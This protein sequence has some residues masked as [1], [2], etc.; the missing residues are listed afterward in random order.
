MSGVKEMSSFVLRCH[1]EVVHCAA[2]LPLLTHWSV[3]WANSHHP[4]EVD[5]SL[6]SAAMREPSPPLDGQHIASEPYQPP[7]PT[8]TPFNTPQT[9]ISKNNPDFSALSS[10]FHLSF[11]PH[12]LF[13]QFRPPIHLLAFYPFCFGALAKSWITTISFVMSVRPSA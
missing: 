8:S 13:V 5:P 7:P 10:H 12:V 1:S 4:S 3:R 2:V 9:A 11:L 6:L